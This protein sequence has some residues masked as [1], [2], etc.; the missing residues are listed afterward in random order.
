MKH[1]ET[2]HSFTYN[3]FLYLPLLPETLTTTI[4]P[5]VPPPSLRSYTGTAISSYLLLIL[6][7]PP[8]RLRTGPHPFSTS[9]PI[10]HRPVL[11]PFLT[12]LSPL[13]SG[14]TNSPDRSYPSLALDGLM[15]GKED[16]RWSLCRFTYICQLVV[17][18]SSV[19]RYPFI[20]SCTRICS[21]LAPDRYTLPYS[22][23]RFETC[24]E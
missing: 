15:D 4:S 18:A 7:Y 16:P 5:S 8:L 23:D 6:P 19:S 14:Y 22:R 1:H 11:L 21:R 2:L 12:L 20:S 3:L 24:F 10:S 13:L 17:F 9:T